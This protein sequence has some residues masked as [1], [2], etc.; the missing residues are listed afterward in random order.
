MLYRHR[1]IRTEGEY[2]FVSPAFRSIF[3]DEN[4]RHPPA[5]GPVPRYGDNFHDADA[6]RSSILTEGL[7]L[8]VIITPEN[9]N[10]MPQWSAKL[11]DESGAV[12]DKGLTYDVVAAI[13]IALFSRLLD[14]TLPP[15][16]QLTVQLLGGL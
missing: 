11:I 13:L 6:L 5:S 9:Q 10:F 8:E 14:R 12:T 7:L 4:G 2:R 16:P 3:V 1:V 15:P